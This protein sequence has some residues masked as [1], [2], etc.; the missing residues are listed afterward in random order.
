MD[1]IYAEK[2]RN[3][4]IIGHG[5]EGKTSLAEAIL[6]NGKTIDRLGK[7][8]DKN[9]VMDFDDQELSRGCSISLACAYTNWEGY[10]INI[11]DV[12]GFFFF[13]WEFESALRAVGAA[14][15]V[16]DANGSVSVGAEKAINYCLKNKIPLILFINGI[17]K[18]NAD[19]ALDCMR[20]AKNTGAALLVL[21]DTN[22]A[23]LPEEIAEITRIVVKTFRRVKIGVHCHDDEGLAV[24]NTM[25]A[26]EAG[27]TH[28]QGTFLGFGERC[29]NCNLIT[30]ILNL[31]L[32][33]GYEILPPEC[34]AKFTDTARRIAETV[35]VRLPNSAPYVGKSAFAHKGGLHG[36][37]VMK[38]PP[39]FEHIDPAVVGNERSFPLSDVAGRAIFL[40]KAADVLPDVTLTD[41]QSETLLTNLKLLEMQGYRFEGADA[42][43][44]VFV[45]KSLGVMPS[46]FG[47]GEYTVGTGTQHADGERSSATVSVN[48][49]GEIKCESASGNGPVDALDN[50]LRKVLSA[51]YPEIDEVILT[52]YKV[53]VLNSEEA[54]KAAVRV[55]ITSSDGRGKSW[56]T[57]GVSTD[58]IDASW[59]ALTDGYEYI[60]SEKRSG[61]N[62]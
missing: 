8:T 2:I 46:F 62:V 40:K 17:D 10:K 39:A 50:A 37:G 49:D 45:R 13:F 42:S 16:A 41:A 52:D 43:F 59:H 1:M 54:T 53:R 30:A 48:V 11:I 26:V 21:C 28:I 31:Q 5:G 24:A 27:A 60:L 6:F 12:P 7:V 22:G 32:K 14:V 61:K 25:A 3:I 4:A 56:S 19:Y 55:L 9:T 51:C 18:E 15:L 47:N 44:A 57:V 58:V 35:N 34:V 38:Y 23:S 36:D 20:T 29:G 33:K